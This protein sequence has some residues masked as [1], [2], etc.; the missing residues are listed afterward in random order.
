MLRSADDAQAPTPHARGRGGKSKR[1]P[2]PDG[3]GGGL[4]A[5][6]PPLAT[7]VP[8]SLAHLKHGVTDKW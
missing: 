6:A 1:G 8:A 5:A 7:R 3:D 4:F 2:L